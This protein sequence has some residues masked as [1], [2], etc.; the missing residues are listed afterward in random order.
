MVIYVD[1]D[2]EMGK[3][4]KT[5]KFVDPK[6]LLPEALTDPDYRL[7]LL[8]RQYGLH[9]PISCSKCHHCR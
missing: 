3:L 7:K 8:E 1:R 2:E 6:S 9:N 5:A 4:K